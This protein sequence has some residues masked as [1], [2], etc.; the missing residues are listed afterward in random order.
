M[1]FTIHVFIVAILAWA[2]STEV[3]GA[4]II[5]EKPAFLDICKRSDSGFGQCWAKNTEKMLQEWRSGVPGLKSIGTLD[6]LHVKRVK[7]SQGGQG[8]PVAFN[9]ELTK[10]EL[11]GLGAAIFEDLG[12]NGNNLDLKLKMTLPSFK[13]NADYTMQGNILSLPLNSH[14]KTRMTFQNAVFSCNAHCKLREEGEFMFVDLEKVQIIFEDIGAVQFRL[15]N[16]FGGNTALEESA[17]TLFNE[18][19]RAIF[20]VLRPSLSQT[21]EIVLKDVLSRI[22]AILPANHYV[23]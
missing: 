15:D 21:T 20:E 10:A 14:G 22:L 4:N 23:M 18:N 11:S 1:N 9:M 2:V 19:W 5:R 8:G 16:L 7:I 13:L 17:H 6:P 3:N 12:S